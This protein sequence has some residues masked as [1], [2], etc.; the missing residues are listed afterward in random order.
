MPP[1]AP[2]PGSQALL[3]IGRIG[4]AHGLRGEVTAVI[5]S[6]REER[7]SPGATW[8]LDAG[9]VLV[10]SIR[11]HQHRWIAVLEGV[12]SREGADA[13]RGQII[14]A[15]EIH[16]PEALWVH[17]LIGATV[18]TPDGSTHGTVTAVLDNPADDI[19]ELDTGA[20]VPVRFVVDGSALPER[21]VVDP[22]LGLLGEVVDAPPGLL[23]AED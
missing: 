21:V 22:P 17:E 18:A 20:L 8:V 6:D 13:L 7:T 23:A 12:D 9:P 2:P 15:T 11:P 14:R 4:K 3:E 1:Q 10:R 19:L 16:D 5:T